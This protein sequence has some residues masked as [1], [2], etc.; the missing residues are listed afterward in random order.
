MNLFE[1]TMKEMYRAP[2]V[3]KDV[4]TMGHLGNEL[5]YTLYLGKKL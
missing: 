4:T 2:E 1:R 5:E 3:N